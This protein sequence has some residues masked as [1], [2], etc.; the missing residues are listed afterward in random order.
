MRGRKKKLDRPARLSVNI[1]SSL[2]EKFEEHTFDPGSDRIPYSARAD[3][4]EKLLRDY[5]RGQD[6][7]KYHRLVGN[8]LNAPGPLATHTALAALNEYH[9]EVEA[10]TEEFNNP[11]PKLDLSTLMS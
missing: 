6:G 1:A 8:L 10:Q 9:E 4:I 7:R 2:I 3:I 11:P 5:F